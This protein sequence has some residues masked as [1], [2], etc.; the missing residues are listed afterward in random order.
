MLNPLEG[1]EINELLARTLT[2]RLKQQ[3]LHGRW[4]S[5]LLLDEITESFLMSTTH[6]TAPYYDMGDYSS[7]VQSTINLLR[8]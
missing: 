2:I 6:P 7:S 5:F 3:K 4:V 1:L 8:I